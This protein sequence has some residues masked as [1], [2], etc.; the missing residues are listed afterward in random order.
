[1]NSRMTPA[2]RASGLVAGYGPARVLHGI[3]LELPAG[4]SLALLGRNGAGKTTL[5][6]A[7]MGLADR[8]AGT[9][10]VGGRD[11]SR[12]SPEARCAA[13]LA[14][15]PQERAVFASLSVEENL[16]AVARAGPWPPGRALSLFPR[17]GERRRQAAGLLSGGEQQMLA[18][19]RALVLSPSVL[20]L[21]EPLEGLA[22]AIS[23]ELAGV[24]AALR[25]EDGLAT[26]LVEQKAAVALDPAEDAVILERGRIV[27]R[28]AS[29]VLAAD[30]ETLRAR[31]GVGGTQAA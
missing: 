8:A 13:G 5:L 30:G 1:G 16:T 27:H 11:V 28:A 7:L 21:D 6:R 26:V 3:D 12:L 24:L 20:L 10:R 18:I 23:A 29:A 15:V 4:G 9:I 19:A 17:L 25:R 31:L 22:P 14:W 2:L